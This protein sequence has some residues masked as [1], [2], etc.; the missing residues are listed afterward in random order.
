MPSQNLIYSSSIANAAGDGPW[1]DVGG[2]GSEWTIHVQNGGSFT[3]EVSNEIPVPTSPN[4]NMPSVQRSNYPPYGPPE[5]VTA[6]LNE[7]HAIAATVVA[8]DAPAPGETFYDRG[9]TFGAGPQ[10]GF[11][12]IYS[13][14]GPGKPG[15]YNVDPTTG[16]YSFNATDV[17]NGYSVNLN[18]NITAP[19]AGVVVPAA[20]IIGSAPN[21]LVIAKSDLNVKW[22]R[23]RQGTPGITVAFLHVGK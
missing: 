11:N 20:Y 14:G 18:Y 12:L 5:T 7:N 13:P 17:A 4:P 23:V 10:T 15:T 9:V 22:V 2:H 8:S 6:N 19:D 1:I 3:V 21:Q 16:T